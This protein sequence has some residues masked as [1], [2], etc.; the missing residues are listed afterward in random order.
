MFDEGMHLQF[1]PIF[2]EECSEEGGTT[3]L[4]SHYCS[5]LVDPSWEGLMVLFGLVA[6]LWLVRNVGVSDHTFRKCNFSLPE[7]DRKRRHDP[8]L[9]R[10]V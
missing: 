2:V 4:E 7:S 6:A 9:V 1:S 8:R 3:D 10:N 5:R